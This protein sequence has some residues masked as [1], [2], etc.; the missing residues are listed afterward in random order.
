VRQARSRAAARAPRMAF[1]ARGASA[2]RALT[3]REITGSEATG[4][5]SS[6]SARRIAA[7]A[8]QSPPSASI[9]ARS[10]MT[11]PGSCT[12]AA[13]HQPLPASQHVRARAQASVRRVAPDGLP[14]GAPS[15]PHEPLVAAYGSSK[16]LG[17][18]SLKRRFP[19]QAGVEPALAG[20]VHEADLVTSG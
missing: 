7:S 2:A 11:L 4:P 20:S 3:S 15:E 6:G 13:R 17:R 18:C 1:S 14:P 19:A 10:V 12:A 8:R 9:T 5:N 16:P